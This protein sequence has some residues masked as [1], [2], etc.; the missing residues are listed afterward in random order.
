MP[1]QMVLEEHSG[2]WGPWPSI[3][4]LSIQPTAPRRVHLYETVM[5]FHGFFWLF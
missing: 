5:A 4:S 1:R 2:M 3:M